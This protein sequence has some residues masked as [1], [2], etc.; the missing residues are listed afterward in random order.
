VTV[1]PSFEAPDQMDLALAALAEHG[2][3]AKVIAGGTALTILMKQGLVEP[4]HLI[5]LGRVPGLAHIVEREDWLSIGPMASHRAIETSELVASRFPVLVATMRSVAT[6]R[7]RNVATLGGNLAHAD[8]ALDPPVTLLALDARL[9]VASSQGE[10]MVPLDEWFVDYYET[11]LRPDEVVIEVQ[12]PYMPARSAAV[13]C[14]FHPRTVDDYATV[15]VATRL[16]V[17]P[18][19]TICDDVRIAL[20]AVGPTAIRAREAEAAIR[21]RPPTMATFREAAA[22]VRGAVAPLSD[23]RGSERYKVQMAEVWVRRALAQAYARLAPA[24]GGD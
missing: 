12:V 2:E 19:G 20:G 21:G 24:G 8:P 1:Y 6:V 4:G 11:V 18:D 23:I 5:G 22:L 3:E 16:S 9:R 17:N 15:A 14:K 7:I 13:F 10:R